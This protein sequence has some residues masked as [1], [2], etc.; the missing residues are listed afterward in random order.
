MKASQ[1]ITLNNT[2][3]VFLHTSWFM[4]LIAELNGH[5][6]GQEDLLGVNARHQTHRLFFYI[7]KQ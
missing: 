4:E 3:E 1:A 6:G 2:E 5:Y 7:N